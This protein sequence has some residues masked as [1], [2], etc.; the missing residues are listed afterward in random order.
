LT[1]STT[2][3][4]IR[5]IEVLA[6]EIATM[7]YRTQGQQNLSNSKDDFLCPDTKIKSGHSP[8]E[9]WKQMLLS[10]R[11]LAETCASAVVEKYPTFAT[12]MDAYNK[13]SNPENAALL[14]MNLEVC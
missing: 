13:A 3:E 12:L 11:G 2:E 14:L 4:T 10:F 7:P 1:T 5:Y 8:T 6:C 9:A